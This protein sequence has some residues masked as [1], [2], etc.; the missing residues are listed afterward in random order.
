MSFCE[1]RRA[2]AQ[3]RAPTHGP[4]A[5]SADH[6]ARNRPGAPQKPISAT[7]S[8]SLA[9]TPAYRL[10]NQTHFLTLHRSSQA[11][12]WLDPQQSQRP[13]LH[14]P[15]RPDQDPSHAAPRECRQTQSPHRDRTAAAA[16]TSLPP[17]ARIVAKVEKRS[18]FLS[19]GT[20][21]RKIA[22]GLSHEPER[23]PMRHPSIQDIE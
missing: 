12:T 13:G 4:S 8:P 9:C 10:T 11:C 5:A 2:H 22:A 15:R 3:H 7:F 1:P 18:G 23:S 14:L 17:R 16:A 6:V 19:N 20:I 21:F